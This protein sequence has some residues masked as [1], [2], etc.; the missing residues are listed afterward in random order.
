MSSDKTIE[1]YW[2][3]F[4]GEEDSSTITS[5][6]TT[7]RCS[8]SK[9]FFDDYDDDDIEDLMVIIWYY[10]RKPNFG[11]S[12]SSGKVCNSQRQQHRQE[13]RL[14]KRIRG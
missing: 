11:V 7:G 8:M 6:A 2:R 5:G 1:C 4:F 10:A 12:C 14:Q 9:K 13:V 3:N